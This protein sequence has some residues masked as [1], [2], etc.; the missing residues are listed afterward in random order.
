MRAAVFQ[1]VRN[2]WSVLFAT[3]ICGLVCNL[4]AQPNT[5]AVSVDAQGA[6]TVGSYDHPILVSGVAA[7]I[8]GQWVH[9]ADY[10]HRD[11]E[12][13]TTDGY[14]GPAEQLQV[15]F[16]GLA[17]KPDLIYQLRAY[18]AIPFADL[19]VKV[20]NNTSSEI[21]VE[22]IR[23]VEAAGSEVV[24]LGGPDS[25]DRILSDSFSEDRPAIKVHD[26]GDA[27]QG[28]YR[29]VGSQLVYNRESHESLFIGALSSERFLT[30]MRLHVH[31]TRIA[32]FEVDSTGTTEM[33]REYALKE[34]PA[35]DRVE[36][37]LPVVAGGEL[38]SET[39]TISVSKDYHRQ[40]EAYGARIRE[41]HHARVSAPSLMGWWSWTSFY[42]GLNEGA[43]LTNAKWEAQHLK[44]L[45]YDVFHI[46]EG[47]QYARGEYT[48]PDESLFPRG[49]T[50]LED[51]VRRL[52]LMPG[53]WT[54]PFEISE[55]AS[56][57]QQHPD[58]LVKNAEGRPI[59]AGL[60]DGKESIYILDT[61]NPGAQ[62]Y[63]RATYRKL[64]QEWG[65]RYIKLDF[66]EDSA[67]E[68]YYYKPH[69]TAM[70]AQ[71]IGLKIIRDTVG[72]S[73]YLDKDGSAMLN[74]VGYVDF[75]RISQ[76][77]AHWFGASR[78][79]ATG[80][81]AR[82][83]MN[84]NF[85][86]S[87][88]DAFTVSRQPIADQSWH[89]NNVSL[90]LD[91]ARVS[92]ALAAVSGGMLEIGDNLPSFEGSSD[93]LALIENRDLIDMARLGRAS[94]PIDLMEFEAADQ[95]PSVFYL[96]ESDRQSV[97]TVFNWTEKPRSKTVRLHDL[98]LSPTKHYKITDVLDQKEFEASSGS[99]TFDR[100]PHSVRVFKIVNESMSPLIPSI[101]E[102]CRASATAGEDVALSATASD[103]EPVLSWQWSFGDGVQA[104]GSSVRHAWT[105]SGDY[106]V[107][108]KANG[109][110]EKSAEKSCRVHVTGHLRTMFVPAAKKRYESN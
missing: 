51:D 26:L 43:A 79:T 58:W 37:S 55:R 110:D 107:R 1:N 67:V 24:R 8:N 47:Y 9:S 60:I 45:G 32:R 93:R 16:S 106:E 10:P 91:E 13:S 84:R 74:P 19:Q 86:D 5:L 15:T 65:I 50:P 17:G 101:T 96:R 14:A 92:I 99:L 82:Y 105:E 95:Q 73:V 71:R 18:A 41:T 3:G 100:R 4:W 97:L 64:V 42:F 53:I 83:Y 94:I 25:A 34:S 61:T 98:G 46:D 56:V 85:Y 80:I 77:T 70:E 29:A 104:E 36:L 78:D 54:A 76:D 89:E 62:E 68:G 59:H 31:G 102:N 66:M 7:K 90:T 109:L 108:V 20:R 39:L 63:L 52:G 27:E 103:A 38:S 33:E 21:S 28:M 23:A 12:K 35:S 49:I 88:P 40:L 75:G 87:D 72:D 48:T 44:S 11:V 22:D 57:Y 30:I 6:Y 2:A 81:A 69:T